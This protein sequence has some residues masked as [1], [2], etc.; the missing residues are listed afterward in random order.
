MAEITFGGVAERFDQA[1]INRGDSKEKRWFTTQEIVDNHLIFIFGA[2]Q[3]SCTSGQR[4]METDNQ[5]MGVKKGQAEQQFV[6][7]GP[8]PRRE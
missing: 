4:A 1:D 7:R 3:H 2:Q 8:S 6:V 5:T